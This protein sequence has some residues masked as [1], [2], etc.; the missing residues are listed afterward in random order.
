MR[1]RG[2]NNVSGRVDFRVINFFVVKLRREKYWY[3]FFARSLVQGVI[4]MIDRRS[5][6]GLEWLED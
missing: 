6:F 3:F 5:V 2:K 4:E 1:G